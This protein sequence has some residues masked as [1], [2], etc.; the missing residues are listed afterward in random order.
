M[1]A[2][3]RRIEMITGVNRRHWSWEQ[4]QPGAAD[5]KPPPGLDVSLP[6]RLRPWQ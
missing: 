5:E 6:P 4:K 2:R 1:S 3:P